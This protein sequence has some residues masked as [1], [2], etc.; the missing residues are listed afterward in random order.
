MPIEDMME[1]ID[2][3]LSDKLL[4]GSDLCIP[5]Y[6]DPNLDVAKYYN[7]R[8][9]KLKAY[10]TNEQYQQITNLNAQKILNVS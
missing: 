5:Q 8:L 4:W 7:S 1:F 3:G 9:G 6:F 2:I 10:C